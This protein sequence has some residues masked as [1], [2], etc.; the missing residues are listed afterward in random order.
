MAD[1]LSEANFFK[2]NVH[3]LGRYSLVRDD[4]SNPED[5]LYFIS[6]SNVSK[7]TS[8]RILNMVKLVPVSYTHLRAHETSAHL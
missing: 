6:G 8:E 3:H 5:V 4:P 7:K 2:R 1:R